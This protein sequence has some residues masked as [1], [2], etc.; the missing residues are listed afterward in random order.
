MADDTID[1]SR[2]EAYEPAE[3][4]SDT[5]SS[6]AENDEPVKDSGDIEK[7]SDIFISDPIDTTTSLTENTDS[8][9]TKENEENNEENKTEEETINTESKSSND[10]ETTNTEQKHTNE[11]TIANSHIAENKNNL[12]SVA[13]ISETEEVDIVIATD[14]EMDAINV[15][16]ATDSDIEP[17][18][19]G[20]TNVGWM[21][22]YTSDSGK[23]LH[24]TSNNGTGYNGITINSSG[25]ISYGL[26]LTDKL[27]FKK[28]VI[29]DEIVADT[30]AYMFGGFLNIT[31]IEGLDKLDTSQVTSMRQM[32]YNCQKLQSLDASSF[33]TSNVVNMSEMFT[34][35]YSLSSLDI[36]SFNTSNVTNMKEM[37]LECHVPSLDVSSFNTSNVTSME[38]MFSDCSSLTT[39][40]LTSFDTS[41]VTNMAKM[42]GQCRKLTT[43][44][45]SSFDTSNV[46]SMEG[47]FNSCSALICLDISN[48]STS[49]VTKT[50]GM[51]SVCSALTTIKVLD[52]LDLSAVTNS[53]GMFGYCTSL[54]GGNGTTID[55][56]PVDKTY[57]HID[58][59]G[60]PG[61]F[62]RKS[63][64][65]ITIE[66]PPTKTSYLVGEN[67][68]GAG[69]V[70]LVTYN[71]AST[72]PVSYDTASADFTF[73]PSPLT[74]GLT[75]VTITYK[76][77]TTTQPVTV[78]KQVTEITQ[79]VTPPTN[80]EY[81]KGDK[82][83]PTGLVIKVKYNDNSTEDIPYDNAHK[84]LF[85]FTPDLTH[86][87]D[88]TDVGQKVKV[89]VGGVTAKEISA[90]Q[91]IYDDSVS[92]VYSD[93]TTGETII[94]HNITQTEFEQFIEEAISQGATGFHEYDANGIKDAKG[95]YNKYTPTTMTKD[96]AIAKFTTT[97]L[98][99][100]IFIGATFAK[101][102]P[103]PVPT[104]GDSGGG[105]GGGNGIS[106][107]AQG[108]IQPGL[109]KEQQVI[110][111]T[112]NIPQNKLI[113]D[114]NLI[115]NLQTYQENR[116]A[117]YIN[118]IDDKGNTGFGKWQHIPNTTTW[119]FLSGDFN[120]TINQTT[121]TINKGTAGLLCNGW[122]NLGWKGRDEWYHFDNKGVMQMGWF[123]E[124]NK[125]YYL[126]T[127]ISS[128]W[129]GR[130]VT[131]Q[132]NING[133]T[134]NFDQSGALLQ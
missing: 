78:R 77:A 25:Q 47:L 108:N 16:I 121:Q 72:K 60:N 118:A 12:E 55:G 85:T 11:S 63:I 126:E 5:T 101:P 113:N 34:R 86:T 17:V 122:Y 94:K 105:S 112:N 64:T 65:S 92:I 29:D 124:N 45:V 102:S 130:M 22:W 40:D 37:F 90:M 10:N 95:K 73:T 70:I 41:N 33:N 49:N 97:G 43:L 119:Y 46:S 30:A 24:L 14:S 1:N 50:N 31:D 62:T 59:P 38:S 32:F 80:T 132:Y 117:Q 9:I 84:D 4:T 3:N 106:Y 71:D 129:Y 69:L 120:N 7:Q 87:F 66:T 58:E 53:T 109:P 56:N 81:S 54:V 61:Y 28:I 48:F 123:T 104:G 44:D 99:K 42:F 20:D 125:I 15:D 67:F 75:Q 13:T 2:D 51:F 82:F 114:N 68:D 74:A 8:T 57:A 83:D 103:A 23:T 93:P 35:C 134:Y 116:M 52:N 88:A 89:S 96:E 91:P 110:N 21:Y 115:N 98:T 76:G 26:S 27:V 128:N 79:I 36:S 133:T 6:I 127:D 107:D 18:V 19:Y 111:T 131:G 39:L 100:T